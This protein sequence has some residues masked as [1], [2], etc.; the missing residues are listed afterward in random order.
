[1]EQ[2]TKYYIMRSGEFVDKI[3]IDKK[4]DLGKK[5]VK[6]QKERIEIK[7]YIDLKD[8]TDIISMVISN[9]YNPEIK[10]EDR[11]N[12]SSKILYTYILAVTEIMTNV[13]TKGNETL[14]YLINS[15]FVEVLKNNILNY[16]DI[17]KSIYFTIDQRNNYDRE[18]DFENYIENIVYEIKDLLDNSSKGLI[19]ASGDLIKTVDELKNLQEHGLPKENKIEIKNKEENKT[20]TRKVAKK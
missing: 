13:E 9:Y 4:Y 17:L 15:G 6:F 18:K 7:P 3:K 10:N 8:A 16:E 5:I 11:L 2:K 14:N 19:E 12:V 20:K 1:M